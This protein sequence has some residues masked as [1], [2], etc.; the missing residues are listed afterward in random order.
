MAETG[1]ENPLMHWIDAAVRVV[2][3]AGYV[4]I[5]VDGVFIY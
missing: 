2:S 1:G 4:R 5:F 3:D